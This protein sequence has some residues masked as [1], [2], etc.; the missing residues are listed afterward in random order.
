MSAAAFRALLEAGDV[1]GLRRAWVDVA[2]HL[3]QPRTREQAEIVMH[4][5]RTSSKTVAFKHRAYSYSWLAE[6]DLPSQLPDELKPRAERM[7]PRI[8]SGVGI[9]VKSDNPLIKPIVGEIRQSMERAVL[10]AEA[11]G[12]LEDATHVQQRM[13]EAR[14]QTYRSLL[15]R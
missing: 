5:T 1:D 4:M 8:V 14:E 6:R 13:R 15:G 9:A 2:P 7:Y 11:D 10:E 12:K 3:P